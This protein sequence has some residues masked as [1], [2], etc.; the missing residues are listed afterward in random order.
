M[1]TADAFWC[2]DKRTA[3]DIEEVKV[4]LVSPGIMAAFFVPFQHRESVK[5]RLRIPPRMHCTGVVILGLQ[6]SRNRAL[7]S[8]YSGVKIARRTRPM[9]QMKASAADVTAGL[10]ALTTSDI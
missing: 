5:L 8:P 9:F 7:F 10:Q 3:A 1:S 4:T 2:H 6:H